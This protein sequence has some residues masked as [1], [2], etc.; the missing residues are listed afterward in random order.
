MLLREFEN[1]YQKL[2]VSSAS[3][4]QVAKNLD[5]KFFVEAKTQEV[6]VVASVVGCYVMIKHLRLNKP[7]LE[8]VRGFVEPNAP[9]IMSAIQLF[10]KEFGLSDVVDYVDGFFDLGYFHQDTELTNTKVNVIL[11]QLN[12]S[13]NMD[14]SSNKLQLKSKD[15]DVK[16]ISIVNRDDIPAMCSSVITDGFTLASLT[17]VMVHNK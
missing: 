14:V 8:F 12:T 5:S 3:D 2:I 16:D 15:Q 1:K 10:G 7:S 4:T 17:K 11:L 6:V 13:F 9:V